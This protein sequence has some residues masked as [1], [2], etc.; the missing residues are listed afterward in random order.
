M[1]LDPLA[2][3]PPL[4]AVN[5]PVAPEPP[6]SFLPPALVVPPAPPELPLSFPQPTRP[7]AIAESVI[8]ATTQTVFRMIALLL[9]G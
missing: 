5:P 7:E 8:K 9:N 4:A 1:E 2:D 6:V 3:D